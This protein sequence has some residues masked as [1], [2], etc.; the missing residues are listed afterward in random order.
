MQGPWR[1]TVDRDALVVAP[2]GT[3]EREWTIASADAVPDD[4]PLRIGPCA[5][6][7]APGALGPHVACMDP[8]QV[9]FPLLLRPWRPGDRMRP[10][11][12]RGSKLIS[13]ILTDAKVPAHRKRRA[14]VLESAGRVL[15]L[16][17]HRLAEGA[18]AGGGAHLRLEWAGD[19][20][21]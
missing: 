11:G 2:A 15:W 19:G 16:C 10:A 6:D 5:G 17:G 3:D 7:H 14:M 4:A 9:A 8:A 13:D 18:G 12:M 21:P 20:P 1:A